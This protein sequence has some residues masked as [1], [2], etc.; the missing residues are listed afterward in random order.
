MTDVVV[1]ISAIAVREL[2]IAQTVQRIVLRCVTGN[3]R[4]ARIAMERFMLLLANTGI[5]LGVGAAADAARATTMAAARTSADL[6]RQRQGSP[7]IMALGAPEGRAAALTQLGRD[8]VTYCGADNLIPFNDAAMPTQR[9]QL[10]ADTATAVSN[11]ITALANIYTFTD[12][13]DAIQARVIVGPTEVR[14]L[15]PV[16]TPAIIPQTVFLALRSLCRAQTNALILGAVAT[17]VLRYSALLPQLEQEALPRALYVGL[18]RQFG[19]AFEAYASPFNVQLMHLSAQDKLPASY[20]SLYGDVNGGYTDAAFGSAGAFTAVAALSMVRAA[21]VWIV[22]PPQVGA[23]IDDAVMHVHSALAQ[24]ASRGASLLVFFI[25]R[26]TLLSTRAYSQLHRSPYLVAETLKPVAW[27]A[28]G[29]RQLQSAEEI[30]AGMG[31]LAHHFAG[32]AE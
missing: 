16:C 31:E 11:G 29:C 20:C 21:P 24:A 18:R 26:N 28:L 5:R 12:S 17:A 9:R 25:L 27:F 22:T 23:V 6:I 4:G 10:G 30:K 3:Q 8:L 14:V 32:W 2:Q 7:I 15:V 13:P 1:P 19:A